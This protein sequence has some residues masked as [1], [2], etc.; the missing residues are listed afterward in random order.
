MTH[1]FLNNIVTR[2]VKTTIFSTRDNVL[3]S[4]N[5]ECKKNIQSLP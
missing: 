2:R 5:K 3:Y 4:T 1:S